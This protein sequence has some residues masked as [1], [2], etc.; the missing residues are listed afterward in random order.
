MH[1]TQE[2]LWF[3]VS[4]TSWWMLWGITYA[5]WTGATECSWRRSECAGV[6]CAGLQSGPPSFAMSYTC[7]LSW[8]SAIL[9]TCMPLGFIVHVHVDGTFTVHACV[10]CVLCVCRGVDYLNARGCFTDPHT[11]TATM[12]DG[13][14]VSCNLTYCVC[15]CVCVCVCSMYHSQTVRC[16]CCC[17]CC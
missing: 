12:Q 4:G 11:L 2:Q 9:H 16:C 7:Q 6:S 5:P 17:C 14:T 15:V 3:H 8:A 1:Y 13:T 10:L